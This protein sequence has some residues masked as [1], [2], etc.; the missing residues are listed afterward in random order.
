[1]GRYIGTNEL[2]QYISPNGSLPATQNG[3]LGSCIVRAESAIDDYT[4]RNFAGTGGT[5]FYNRYY[6][7]FVRNNAFYLDRDLFSL[8]A[9]TNGA[10]QVIPIGSLW[11]EPQAQSPPYRIIRLMTTYV[12]T[13]N[14]DQS[15]VIVGTWGYS[16][17]PPDAII[18]ACVRYS[19]WLYRQKDA[20]GMAGVEVTGFQDSGE[21]QYP[22]GM[23]DDV[24]YLLSPYRSRSGGIV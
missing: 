19:A 4:R 18:Q 11:L 2:R 8:T 7:D 21:T 12:Y 23:P 20:G 17:T 9:L 16:T 15:M 3:L 1:M 5:V 6:D 22:K 13:W 14:T 10:S 24:R